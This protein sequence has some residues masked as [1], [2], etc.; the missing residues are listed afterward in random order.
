MKR[1]RLP[2]SELLPF[3]NSAL[4]KLSQ[5]QKMMVKHYKI[6]LSKKELYLN[7]LRL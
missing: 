5:P 2:F 7:A 6:R 1:I 3:L 4:V